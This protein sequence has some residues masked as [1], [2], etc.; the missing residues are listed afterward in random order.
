VPDRLGEAGDRVRGRQLLPGI[1]GGH[2][3]LAKAF[4]RSGRL[5]S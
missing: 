5:P 3:R 1:D 2:E 4:R